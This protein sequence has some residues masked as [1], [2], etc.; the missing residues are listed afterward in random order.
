MEINGRH[1]LISLFTGVGG[2]DYGF[3]AA[4]FDTAVSVELDRVA[5]QT[6]RTNRSWPLLEGSICDFSSRQILTAGGLLAGDV[7]VLIGGPPCQP[8]SKAGYWNAGDAAR[9]RDPRAGTLDEYMRVLRDTRP[10]AF[11]LENVPGLAFSGKDEGLR[12]I[13]AGIQ[14]IN[15]S[16]KTKYVVSLHRFNA[17]DFGVPQRRERIFLIGFRDG[18][19]FIPPEPTH[20]HPDFRDSTL[21]PYVT[22][23]DAIG[24]LDGDEVIEELSIKGKWAGLVPSIPEGQNYLWHTDRGGGYPLFGWRTRYWSFLLKLAKN[25]PSWTIQAQPGPAIGPF[26]WRSRKLSVREMCRLQTL[27]DDLQFHCGHLDAQRLVGNAVPSLMAEVLARSIRS[28]LTGKPNSRQKYR[29]TV[30]YRGRAP[31]PERQRGVPAKYRQLTGTYEA[32]PGTGKGRGAL[33]RNEDWRE[34]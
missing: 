1:K 15:K 19:P 3:E 2:L 8:F 5:C 29:L 21:S 28:Q 25:Q 18:R 27:P 14:E 22:A 4:G 31:A 20:S 6:L 10:R 24:D 23:W 34:I 16:K 11:L 32:H 9:M 33:R 13:F 30:P 17:A 26:H 12:H 7:D